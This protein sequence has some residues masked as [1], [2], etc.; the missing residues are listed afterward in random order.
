MVF[1]LKFDVSWLFIRK[2]ENKEMLLPLQNILNIDRYVLALV[3]GL[4][5]FIKR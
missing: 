1:P 5:S 2:G 4:F 3:W